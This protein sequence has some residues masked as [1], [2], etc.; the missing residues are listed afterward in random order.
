MEMSSKTKFFVCI[1][2]NVISSL[3]KLNNE[4]Q[5]Q[6]IMKSRKQFKYFDLFLGH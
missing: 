3:K 4:V 1:S 2:Q 5:A 6:I